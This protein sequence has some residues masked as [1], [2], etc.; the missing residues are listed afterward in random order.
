MDI[1]AIHL[2]YLINMLPFDMY[3][4]YCGNRNNRVY[5]LIY[6][7]RGTKQDRD[8]KLLITDKVG[9]YGIHVEIY[10]IFDT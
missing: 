5:I 9:I 10:E 2:Q 6:Y 1:L 8:R 4:K 3:L 7:K